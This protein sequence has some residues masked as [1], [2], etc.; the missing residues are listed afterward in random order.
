MLAFEFKKPNSENPDLEKNLVRAPPLRNLH[1]IFVMTCTGVELRPQKHITKSNRGKINYVDV[2]SLYPFICK[3]G[4]FP[5]GHPKVYVGA[6]YPPD[7][8]DKEGVMKCKFCPPPRKLFHP[9]LPYKCNSKL[10]FPLCSAC[11]NTM[12]QGRCTQSDEV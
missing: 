7:Y 12:N 10:M 8:L 11:A 3:Y 2:I 6:S 9:V 4:K 5:V 1:L